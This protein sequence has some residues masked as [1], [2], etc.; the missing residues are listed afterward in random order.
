MR[1]GDLVVVP[2]GTPTRDPETDDRPTLAEITV[3]VAAIEGDEFAWTLHRGA[4]RWAPISASS[5]SPI[6]IELT[7]EEKKRKKKQ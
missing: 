2:K 7:K 6:V 1:V 3:K 5:P 4:L